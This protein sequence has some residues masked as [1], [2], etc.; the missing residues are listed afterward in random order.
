MLLP[1]CMGCLQFDQF[2]E[3]VESRV[4]RKGG[5]DDLKGCCV[6]LDGELNPS[7]DRPG[8]FVELH[9]EL[10]LNGAS[11]DKELPVF[12]RILNDPGAVHYRT[13]KFIEEVLG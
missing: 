4:L 9:E 6:R 1:F 10:G 3:L 12:H 8:I 11:S 13:F 2:I 7:P 5:R